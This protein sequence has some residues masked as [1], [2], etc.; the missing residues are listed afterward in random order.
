MFIVL[1][2]SI[3]ILKLVIRFEYQLDTMETFKNI[4]SFLLKT[5]VWIPAIWLTIFYIFT[6]LCW[7]K[8]G[9]FPVP[10]LNDPKFIG[11][12][13]FHIASV[14]GLILSVYG[15]IVWMVILPFSIKFK[16]LTKNYIIIVSICFFFVMI[17]LLTDPYDMI[18]WLLD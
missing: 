2:N 12:P 3:T 10:S 17:L 7:N 9:H 6:F 8:L 13:N 1:K 5:L 15:I 16:L 11:Y 4:C 18:I 14:V